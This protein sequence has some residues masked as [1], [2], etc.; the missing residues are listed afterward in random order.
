MTE[1]NKLNWPKI[2]VDTIKNGNNDLNSIAY[3][4]YDLAH[5]DG[6]NLTYINDS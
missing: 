2:L 6:Q 1:V 5:N 3:D 4:L